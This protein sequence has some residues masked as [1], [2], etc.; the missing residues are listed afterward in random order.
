MCICFLVIISFLLSL[1][2]LYCVDIL[3]FKVFF[4]FLFCFIGVFS[5]R[6]EL[7]VK[8]IFI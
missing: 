6:V 7:F 8:D 4:K 2:L 5:L 3:I 1:I